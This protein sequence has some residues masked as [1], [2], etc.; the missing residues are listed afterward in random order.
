MFIVKV[1]VI[2][3]L[4]GAGVIGKELAGLVDEREF[5]GGQRRGLG[6]VE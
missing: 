5:W 6:V 3:E 2:P 4:G 1:E